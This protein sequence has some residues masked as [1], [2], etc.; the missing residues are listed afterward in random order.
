MIRLE[1]DAP[2]GPYRVER[3][4]KDGVFNSSYVVADGKGGRFFL[5]LFNLRIG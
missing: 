3:F 4:I 2:V 5:K 1:N